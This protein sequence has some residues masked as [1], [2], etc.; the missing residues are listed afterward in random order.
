MI[1]II[2]ISYGIVLVCLKISFESVELSRNSRRVAA[3]SF[4]W[5]RWDRTLSLD[6]TT[7]PFKC[8]GIVTGIVTALSQVLLVFAASPSPK[9][10]SR[11]PL[12]GSPVDSDDWNVDETVALKIQRVLPRVF[13]ATFH[14]I[15]LDEIPATKVFHGNGAFP[16]CVPDCVPRLWCSPSTD[17][18]SW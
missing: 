8:V 4:F 7:T 11:R 15:P 10:S 6:P 17:K 18:L 12:C 9:T 14:S 2:Q 1:H 5:K 13:F 3:R 16:D